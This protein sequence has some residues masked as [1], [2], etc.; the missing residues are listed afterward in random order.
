MFV[1][2]F[3]WVGAEGGEEVDREREMTRVD[4]ST[5][6]LLHTIPLSLQ[7]TDLKLGARPLHTQCPHCAFYI[8]TKTESEPGLL[9][10]LSSS[11]LCC[12]GWDISVD[13]SKANPLVPAAVSAPSSRV[14]SSLS[15]TSLTSVLSATDISGPTRDCVETLFKK[16]TF[17]V[18]LCSVSIS[19]DSRS[20]R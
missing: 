17:C 3:L 14:T 4:T 1:F 2:L 12:L 15:M 18:E 9:V 19:L 11:L 8:V 5:V 7:I 16:T 10:C 6:T 20:V 13:G